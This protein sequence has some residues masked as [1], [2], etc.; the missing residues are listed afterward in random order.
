MS[1]KQSDIDQKPHS[2]VYDLGLHCLPRPVCPNIRVN[3]VYAMLNGGK[4]LSCNVQISMCIYI[5]RS[6]LSLKLAQLIG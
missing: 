6:E 2:V 4:G 5:V 1:V 3:R